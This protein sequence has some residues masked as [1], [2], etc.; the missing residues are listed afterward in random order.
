[1]EFLNYSKFSLDS[2][3]SMTFK[4][5]SRFVS[6]EAEDYLDSTLEKE[7]E[8]LSAFSARLAQI[9]SAGPLNGH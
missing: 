7:L 5:F 3:H 2:S 9:E 4:L 1:M 8:C 6:E